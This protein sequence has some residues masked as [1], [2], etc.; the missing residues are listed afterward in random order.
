MIY[1]TSKTYAEMTQT[2]VSCNWPFTTD[3]VLETD[4]ATG[5]IKV[6]KLFGDQVS[7]CENWSS[8]SDAL[9]LYPDLE[10]MVRIEDAE[11]KLDASQEAS[12]EESHKS[13]NRG[14][15]AKS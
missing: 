12:N 1:T 13:S 15:R 2:G 11:L 3:D 4:A 9:I 5:S 8:N 7:E 14:P 10:G 6:L